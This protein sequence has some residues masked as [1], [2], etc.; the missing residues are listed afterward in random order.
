MPELLSAGHEVVRLDNYSKYGPVERSPRYR[1]V[2]GDAKDA[3]LLGELLADCDHFVTGAAIFGG[4]TLFHERAYDLLAENERITAAAFD[5]AVQAH[6][7]ARLRKI[8]VVSSSMV[9]ESASA[10][11]DHHGQPLPANL[12]KIE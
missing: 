1:G 2:T 7:E 8:T 11:P 6:R 10:Y 12:S 9:Y 4:I 3:G 5:A